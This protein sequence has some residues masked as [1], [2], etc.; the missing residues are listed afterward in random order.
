M[1]LTNFFYSLVLV[2]KANKAVSLLGSAFPI[3]ANGDLLTCRH[4][5]D[6][7]SNEELHMAVFDYE[8]AKFCKIEKAQ[9]KYHQDPKV[10][11]AFIIN[12]FG[13]PKPQFFPILS[14]NKLLTGEDVYTYGKYALGG[15][16]EEITGGYFS[17][18]IINIYNDKTRELFL[19]TLP[20]PI[21]E[22]LSGS[23]VLTYHNG[24]KLVGICIGNQA[25]RIL[26]SEV[27]EYKDTEKEYKETINR[28]VEFGLAI[29]C[30][31]I[32]EFLGQMNLKGFIVSDQSVPIVGME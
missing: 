11:L 5:V 23:P 25:Q 12:P 31:H 6:V 19:L 20:Y 1:N 7:I 14:P 13:D 16:I 18:R 26:A 9:I 3:T 2:N 4:V 10:D 28:I 30:S 8:N 17:G 21:I 22:G 24:P 27:L 29:H 32:I 15:R